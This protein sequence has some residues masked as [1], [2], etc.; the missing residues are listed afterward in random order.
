MKHCIKYL[1][2]DILNS[3]MMNQR[4]PQYLICFDLL[5]HPRVTS[6]PGSRMEKHPASP[7]NSFTVQRN[8]PKRITY[9]S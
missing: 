1:Y 8:V 4:N 5:Y 7:G 2:N 6:C 3:A 9:F